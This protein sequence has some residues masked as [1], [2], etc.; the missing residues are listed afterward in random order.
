MAE[1]TGDLH[2]V[3]L[4]KML[5]PKKFDIDL[6]TPEKPEELQSRLRREEAEDAHKHRISLYLH[7][8]IMAIVAVALLTSIYLVVAG[9]PKT[10]LPDKAQATITAIVA[11]GLGYITGK[12]S[13]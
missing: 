11:A 6:K 2:Q 4:G 13:K 1:R 3:D 9:D 12:G 5:D 7:L 8:F 10:G